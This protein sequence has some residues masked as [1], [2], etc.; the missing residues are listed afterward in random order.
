MFTENLIILHML[1]GTTKLGLLLKSED[2]ERFSGRRWCIVGCFFEPEKNTKII[3]QFYI[4]LL[5]ETG[6]KVKCF[7]TWTFHFQLVYTVEG[8]GFVVY[9]L[10]FFF[11][12]FFGVKEV[13]VYQ[14]SHL[15]ML[16]WLVMSCWF[17]ILVMQLHDDCSWFN[18]CDFWST[19]FQMNDP[20][21]QW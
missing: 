13:W 21:Y 10:W 5:P 20:Y 2:L 16:G 1:P 15:P 6:K 17:L 19:G 4:V 14:T 3:G 9:G 12:Y 18:S 11:F 8:E 7:S